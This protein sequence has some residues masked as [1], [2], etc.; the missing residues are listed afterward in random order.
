M[1]LLD[2]TSEVEV[3]LQKIGNQIELFPLKKKQT[4]IQMTVKTEQ[5]RHESITTVHVTTQGSTTDTSGLVVDGS[6][7]LVVI[8]R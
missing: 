6:C 1:E 7:W 2:N 8:H 4:E 5:K 3:A